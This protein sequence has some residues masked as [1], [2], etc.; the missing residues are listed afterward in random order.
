MARTKATVRRM[1]DNVRKLSAWMSNREYGGRKRA[2]CPFK[3]KQT[4]PAQKRVDITKNGQFVKTIN[5]KRK[6]KHFSGK[7]RLFF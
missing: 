2:V 5:V 3:I 1:P 6:S 7:N 4:L